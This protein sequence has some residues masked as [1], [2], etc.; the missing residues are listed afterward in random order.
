MS[1]SPLVS[2]IIPAYNAAPYIASA[3]DSVLGQTYQNLEVLVIDDG[4]TDETRAVMAAYAADPRVRYHYQ[5]NRGE[6]GARN[7]GLRLARGEFI[8]LCDADDLWMPG[9]LEV[10]IPCFEGKP[11][12]GVVYTNTVHVDANN[13]EIETYQTQRHNGWICERLFMG[14][15]VTGSTSVFRRN[16]LADECYDEALKTS[17]DYDLSLRLSLKWQFEYLDVVTYRY[18]IWPGQVSNPANVLRFYEDA[19]QVRRKFLA[20]HPGRI[21]GPAVDEMWAG[22]YSGRAQA[23]MRLS[24]RRHVAFGDIIRSLRI[25]PLRFQTWKSLAKV[26]LNRVD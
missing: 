23:V 22:L 21:P 18:R 6:A 8:A 16:C 5:E 26:L 10:Q 13:Q 9:K 24:R 2:V 4:S 11:K 1:G 7:A 17:A 25:K 15:F 14:N 12:L 3:V 20:A 19:I